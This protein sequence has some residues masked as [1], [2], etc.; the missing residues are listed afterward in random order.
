[1]TCIARGV[2]SSCQNAAFAS[3]TGQTPDGTRV[4]ASNPAHY[5][6]QAEASILIKTSANGNDADLP[7][8]PSV[9]IGSPVQWTYTL[10][11]TGKVA[12]SGLVVTARRWSTIR[13]RTRRQAPRSRSAARF[14]GPTW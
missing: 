3:V 14:P 7:P 1:M 13:T 2:A 4:A 12:L 11:N 8:G 5:F 6:G 9:P 10:T